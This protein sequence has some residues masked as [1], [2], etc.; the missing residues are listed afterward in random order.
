MGKKTRVDNR[1]FLEYKRS[2]NILRRLE[3][4]VLV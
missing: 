4:K 2:G 1:A 3:P